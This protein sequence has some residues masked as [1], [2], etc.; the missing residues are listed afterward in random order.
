ME[1]VSVVGNAMVITACSS[2]Y[3]GLCF[4]IDGM[5]TDFRN[6]INSVHDHAVACPETRSAH[7][8]PVYVKEFHFHIEIIE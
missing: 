4:Y 7:A 3:I 6:R 1:L 2:L 8:W 5:V